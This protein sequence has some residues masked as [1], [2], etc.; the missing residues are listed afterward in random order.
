MSDME[1]NFEIDAAG[2][3]HDSLQYV[4]E[5]GAAIGPLA[6]GEKVMLTPLDEAIPS[7]QIAPLFRG[8][9][10][11]LV[12]KAM[13]AYIDLYPEKTYISSDS[14][15]GGGGFIDGLIGRFAGKVSNLTLAR[16]PNEE[17]DV[18]AFFKDAKTYMPAPGSAPRE[19][20]TNYLLNMDK[21]SSG[22]PAQ[23]VMARLAY[24]A[25]G[26]NPRM[27]IRPAIRSTLHVM[28]DKTALDLQNSIDTAR[29]LESV[30]VINTF[31]GGDASPK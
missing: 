18:K 1:R 6:V 9:D 17:A 2:L 8:L 26:C 31:G 27:G 21:K 30:H 28:R 19:A 24:Y 11:I 15:L 29:M 25:V 22:R 14:D 10:Y 20:F 13:S 12:G 23:T 3:S 4:E 5:F 16:I 7:G